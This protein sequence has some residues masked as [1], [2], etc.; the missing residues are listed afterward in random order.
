MRYTMMRNEVVDTFQVAFYSIHS[1]GCSRIPTTGGVQDSTR[2]VFEWPDLCRLTVISE[3]H[4][5]TSEVP[6]EPKLLYDSINSKFSGM[7][8]VVSA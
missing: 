7:P 4:K 8:D 6:F 2:D 3:L 5:K 1:L